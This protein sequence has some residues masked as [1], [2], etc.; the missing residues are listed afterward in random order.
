MKQIPY[1]RQYIDQNDIK[2][3]SKV[4][5]KDLITSGSEVINFEKKIINYLKCKYSTA[6][7][8]GTSAILLALLSIGLKKND[9]VIMPSITFIASYNMASFIG[10]K[11]Y[12]ADVNKISGQ[13]SPEDVERC[14]KKFKLKKIKAIITMYN[15]G[16]PE[17]VYNFYK[18][19]KKFGCYLIEDAC[20][21]LGAEYKF[22]KKF[23][24][25]GSCKHSDISTFSLH[26]LKTITTGEG[27]LVTTN[28]KNLDKKI[29]SFR[30]LGIKKN[31]N[32]HWKYNVSLIGFN[33]R[34]NEFQCALGISQLNKIKSFLSFRKKI[35]LK[36]NQELKKM[37][38][39]IIPKYE[40]KNKPAYHLYLISIKNF[41]LQKKN[42]FIKFMKSKGIF[43]Q[44]HYIPI[45]KFKIFKDKYFGNNS[46]IYYNTS[47]SIPIYF[48]LKLK[49]QNY[50]IK[51]IKLFFKN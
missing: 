3:V 5:K 9:V 28:S 47:L 51:L 32:Y 43:V 39:L 15:G 35:A 16:Y 26:P 24:K 25:I 33:F 41:N 48:G 4:L 38:S 49:D 34:L 36:Y 46:E 17:N 27:G 6:C 21:A 31:N 44:Y 30:S 7:N 50:I 22:N 8:S 1:G 11:I 18:L 2:S 23:Y 40:N 19:K 13:M 42:K 45:Y 37:S 12:L 14:C 29:K 20:H 10:A